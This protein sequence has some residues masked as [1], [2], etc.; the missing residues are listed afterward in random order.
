M[1]VYF[2]LLM[3]C[4]SS[5]LL[6]SELEAQ[7]SWQLAIA[8]GDA[9]C[10]PAPL[11]LRQKGFSD[12]KVTARFATHSFQPPIYYAMKASRYAGAD[13]WEF[14]FIHLK[15]DLKNKNEDI[16]RFEVSHGFNLFTLLRSWK[17]RNFDWQ[18]GGGLVL[19]HPENTV[20]NL[21]I[22]ETNGLFHSGY[23]IA[24]PNIQL[25]LARTLI[26]RRDFS[27]FIS[28]KFTG[29]HCWIPIAAGQSQLL[30]FNFHGL[31]GIVYA[32]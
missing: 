1:K 28:G 6:V 8:L 25:A 13:G 3:L 19:A 26:R 17:R 20:R 9:Y 32:F 29:A 16:Q 11:C 10:V 2:I 31:F 15:I 5:V 23:Y 24:G 4:W 22:S 12:I 18:I 7:H 30:L 14:E 21:K 27:I